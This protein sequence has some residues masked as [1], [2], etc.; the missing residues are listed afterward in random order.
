[1]AVR[2][3]NRRWASGAVIA[4]LGA[5]CSLAGCGG[6]D[7]VE[8]GGSAATKPTTTESLTVELNWLPSAEHVG[9]YYGESKGLFREA[10]LAPEIHPPSDPS[11]PLKLLAAGRVDIA[12][13]FP[14]EL[15]I[16]R[17]KGLDL[18][19][20]GSVVPV[21]LNALIATADSGVTGPQALPGKKLGWTAGVAMVD[22]MLKTMAKNSGIELDQVELVNVGFNA[23]AAALSGKVDA[24]GMFY[25]NGT[26]VEIATQTGQEPLVIPVD[27][28]GFPTYDELVLVANGAQLSSD[29]EYRDKVERFVAAYQRSTAAALDDPEG[30]L[31]VIQEVTE[32]KPELIERQFDVTMPLLRPTGGRALGCLAPADWETLAAFLRTE[33]FLN[34]D[35]TVADVATNEYAEGCD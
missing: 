29:A 21:P 5:C 10:G 14:A 2:I 26:A 18:V 16:A 33:G 27:E 1:V 24:V 23:T 15:M 25:R 34:A 20:V 19:A 4:A 32:D 13:S 11:A 28:L 7:E 6:D 35:V 30:G 8:G 31:A 17:E 9:L 3:S 22:V 12:V